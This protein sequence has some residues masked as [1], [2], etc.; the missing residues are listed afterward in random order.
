MRRREPELETQQ[1]LLRVQP[2]GGPSEQSPK[3]AAGRALLGQK[4]R[5]PE[6]RQSEAP[7]RVVRPEPEHWDAA[8]AR[9]QAQAPRRRPVWTEVRNAAKE[10]K[11]VVRSTPGP[12]PEQV[13]NSL[14]RRSL[15]F[16]RPDA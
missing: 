9:S 10:R 7:L 5:A 13:V 1:A 2:P 11:P 6:P 16:P 12:K 8:A 14:V 3:A 4:A 15:A